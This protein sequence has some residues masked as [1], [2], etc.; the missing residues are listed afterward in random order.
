MRHSGRDLIQRFFVNRLYG[1]RR[2]EN[3]FLVFF[4]QGFERCVGRR[5]QRGLFGFFR[6]DR[7]C[8]GSR[9]NRLGSGR[10]NFRSRLR[11]RRGTEPGPCCLHRRIRQGNFRQGMRW[12][13]CLC[14]RGRPRKTFQI[15][16]HRDR[17]FH[18]H[19]PFRPGVLGQRFTRQHKT[20]KYL[21]LVDRCPRFG[22][23]VLGR[24]FGARGIARSR[25][26]FR[27]LT[28]RGKVLRF[29]NSTRIS[30]TATSATASAATLIATLI[31]ATIRLP[32]I[33]ACFAASFGGT[34]FAGRLALWALRRLNA[35]GG[36]CLPG[37]FRCRRRN[38]PQFRRQ[39]CG[40]SSFQLQYFVFGGADNTVVFVV[41]FK[42]V[43][44]IEERVALQS[45]VYE[46][47][48]HA[49]QY[50]GDASF[51]NTACEGILFFTLVE[52]LHQLVVFK[53]RHSCLVAP[54]CD[55]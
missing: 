25:V 3:S 4:A 7:S 9:R 45:N 44:D 29:R 50:P 49:G 47:G 19:R 41:I 11:N 18:F 52:N 42:E 53:D 8:R 22:F 16:L 32:A 35:F 23:P 31:A 20:L 27:T 6:N 5:N 40:A 30:P 26:P 34:D 39:T 17:G 1:F 46:C 55:D 14:L 38:R 37:K 12:F 13:H 43:G 15:V 48:L 2:G 28:T 36:K 33:G 54:R 10:R 24:L 21:R 51:V